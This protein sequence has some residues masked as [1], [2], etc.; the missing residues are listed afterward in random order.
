MRRAA[1]ANARAHDSRDLGRFRSSSSFA[2]L[3]VV[4]LGAAVRS[5]PAHSAFRR[6]SSGERGDGAATTTLRAVWP[7]HGDC[8]PDSRLV[9]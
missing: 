9:P 8:E 1:S 7:L 2:L 4:R 3:A 5:G 6:C